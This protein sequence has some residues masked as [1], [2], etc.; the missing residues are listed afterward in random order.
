MRSVLN[1]YTA[2]R[3][4][5][6]ARE[7]ICA[8]AV[9]G[10]GILALM[11]GLVD[12]RLWVPAVAAALAAALADL[13]LIIGVISRLRAK[14]NDVHAAIS[15]EAGIQRAGWTVSE[16]FTDG[17]AANPSLQ[18][19]HLKVLQFVK[20]KAI[21]ELGSGQTTKV[22]SAY[23]RAMPASY[24]L[25]LEQDASWMQRLAPDVIHDYRHAR[26][27]PRTFTCRGSN[28]R[29][30]TEWY[31]EIPELHARKF[32]YILVDGPDLRNPSG[33]RQTTRGQAF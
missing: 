21:L 17:A 18:L 7:V 24:I 5:P 30:T 1:L 13:V 9:S 23:A 8:M 26:I 2:L 4:S 25:S 14:V 33:K 11:A 28:L 6:H 20:P 32:D 22:L 19:L 12:R 31:K 16:F 10:L 3:R 15:L 27:V 29:L